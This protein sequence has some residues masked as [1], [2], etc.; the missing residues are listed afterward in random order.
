MTLRALSDV[1]HPLEPSILGTAGRAGALLERADARGGVAGAD[2]VQLVGRAGFGVEDPLRVPG[3]EGGF[4]CSRRSSPPRPF[5]PSWTA[6]AS[7]PA[8]HPWPPPS[9]RRRRPSSASATSLSLASR[10]FDESSGASAAHPNLAESLVEFAQY[11]IEARGCHG[12]EAPTRTPNEAT[13]TCVS[14]LRETPRCRIKFVDH[15]G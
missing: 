2:D 9:P 5:A 3:V 13:R 4:A 14:F 7:L 12:G 6:W 15:G 11:G 10:A 1:E 8:P